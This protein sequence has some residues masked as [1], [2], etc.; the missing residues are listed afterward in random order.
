MKKRISAILLAIAVMVTATP[1]LAFA[2]VDDQQTGGSDVVTVVPD[3]ESTEDGEESVVTTEPEEEEEAVVPAEPEAEPAVTDEPAEAEPAITEEPAAEEKVVVK[4]APRALTKTAGAKGETRD[5]NGTQEE[6]P[7]DEEPLL[8]SEDETAEQDVAPETK[9]DEPAV[10]DLKS[11]AKTARTVTLT[12]QL[13]S[14]DNVY[15]KD[16]KKKITV[17]VGKKAKKTTIKFASSAAKYTTKVTGLK[18]ATTYTFKVSW[19]TKKGTVYKT[20][21]V[22]TKKE[23]PQVKGF[24]ALSTYNGVILKWKRVKGA[25]GYIIKWKAGKKKVKTIK[26]K[27]GKKVEYTHK[28]P[29]NLR[30]TKIKYTIVAYKNNGQKSAIKSE[31]IGEAVRTMHISI[32]FATTRTLTS[33]DKKPV[34]RTFKKGTTVKAFGYDGNRYHFMYKGH[35]FYVVKASIV[36]QTITEIDLDKTYS[37]KEAENFVN[38]LGLGSS[39]VNLIWVN[40]YTQSLYVFK[41]SKGKWKV[42]KGAWDVSTGLP[43]T[44]TPTGTTRVGSKSR[45]CYDPFPQTPWW[46]V[47]RAGFS[48]HGKAPY[49]PAMGAPA[50]HGCVRNWSENAKWTYEHIP[51]NTTVHVF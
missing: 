38:K 2:D 12:W 16:S 30:R 35:L 22:K 28:L 40:T 32:T 15:T 44:P 37:K 9:S 18:P 31:A 29:E 13:K 3:G 25:N 6:K 47:C 11:T 27:G 48:I 17:Y 43:K 50:S 19:K 8:K 1:M 21:K 49:Y 34:T 41:G 42:Q 46:C 39:T 20:I 45:G 23:F 10:A 24:K 33:H 7:Q 36:G 14:G 51:V 4:S 26:V 5:A